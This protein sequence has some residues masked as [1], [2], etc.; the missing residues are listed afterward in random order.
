[1][2]E[3]L[4][5]KL[6]IRREEGTLRSL[7]HFDGFIDFFS[8]D[9]LG[10]AGEV[11]S[12]SVWGSTG[13]RLISGNSNSVLE[14]E[15]KLA[16]FF[17]SEAAL[18]FNS[19]Y[20]A[21]L[22]FFGSVP[23][24][25]DTVVYDELIHASVRDGIRLG[26]ANG[27]SFKHNDADDLALKLGK[28]E[29][30]VYVAVESLYS[31]N[32]DMAPLRKIADICEEYK[33]NLVVDEAHAAGVFGK[34]GRGIVDALGLRE[35]VFA[36]LVTFGKAYGSH[37]ACILGSRQL[38]NFLIN[39]SRSFIYTTALP[40]EVYVH[41]ASIVSSLLMNERRSIL[42][43]NLNY[44]RSR[45]V[46][47]RLISEVNS[48]IQIVRI[49]NVEQVK[50]L[51]ERLQF[52]NIAVKPIYAPTVQKGCEALRLCIHSFNTK[53]ELDQLISELTR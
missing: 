42:Q 37:G 14:A 15:R 18:M 45:F 27:M 1:M 43:D 46:N 10:M 26:F 53:T 6:N 21:N 33:V 48:P 22:G 35:K 41:N 19:G 34:D 47:D 11:F 32:G 52:R 4:I 29:G 13:S 40:A 25:G 17:S 38:M 12:V 5:N 28:L 50:A 2:D 51:T 44:F 36:R 9:Y 3:R 31:M 49:G 24:R 7:S 20:D 23:Q 30:T 39:F 8:N 16:N